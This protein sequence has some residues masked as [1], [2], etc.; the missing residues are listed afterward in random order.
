MN[1]GSKWQIVIPS[2]PGFGEQ[3]R[4]PFGPNE[5]VIIDVELV[6]IEKAAKAQKTE[7][8]KNEGTYARSQHFM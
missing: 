3:G 8:K 6:L 4:G 2:S 1:E 7:N 5:V